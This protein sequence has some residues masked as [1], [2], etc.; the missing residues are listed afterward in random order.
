MYGAVY[1]YNNYNNH[2]IFVNSKSTELPCRGMRVLYGS[3]SLFAI[4]A[5]GNQ[6]IFSVLC[7][8]S[9]MAGV[10]WQNHCM[11]AC[12]NLVGYVAIYR[13]YTIDLAYPPPTWYTAS[14]P[15]SFLLT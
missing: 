7:D 1:Y 13:N 3:E 9:T 2:F 8:H 12:T 14:Y 6:S 10:A 15:G 11:A 4:L 5:P